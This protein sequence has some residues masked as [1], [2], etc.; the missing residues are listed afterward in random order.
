MDLTSLPIQSYLY[1]RLYNSFTWVMDGKVT[2][3]ALGWNVNGL[4]LHKEITLNGM[5]GF[6]QAKILEFSLPSDDP[7][8]GIDM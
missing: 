8:G 7:N 1:T 3:G 4:S 2:V 6:T 5:G